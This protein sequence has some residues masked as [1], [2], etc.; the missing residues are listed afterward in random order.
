[1]QGKWENGQ[2]LRV[3]N[4]FAKGQREV[5]AA[6]ST[7]ITG[8]P[9]ILP[10]ATFS[11]IKSGERMCLALPG[12]PP[13]SNLAKDLQGLAFLSATE[14]K[15]QKGHIVGQQRDRSTFSSGHLPPGDKGCSR[16]HHGTSG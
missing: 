1:M 4:T 14:R 15:R 2:S 6:T 7:S 8:P 5:Q 10:L 13:P 9:Q 3:T 12:Q 16:P 11:G